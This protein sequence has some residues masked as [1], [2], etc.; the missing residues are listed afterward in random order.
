MFKTESKL[1]E[2]IDGTRSRVEGV[3]QMGKGSQKAPTSA[4]KEV[5]LLKQ[6][7]I[8]HDDYVNITVLHV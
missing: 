1:I 5:L 8:Q 6:F 4:V 2:Q 3:G 7:N